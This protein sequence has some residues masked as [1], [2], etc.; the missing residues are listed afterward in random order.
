MYRIGEPE[1]GAVARVIRGR[2]LFRYGCSSKETALFEK[3]LTKK[4]GKRVAA[5]GKR[6]ISSGGTP[7]GMSRGLSNSLV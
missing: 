1:I 2:E 7:G 4:I 6:T 5:G 3:E